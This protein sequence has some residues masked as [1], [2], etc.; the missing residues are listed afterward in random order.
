MLSG[1]VAD[2][3]TT[4][5]A[6]ELV[7]HSSPYFICILLFAASFELGTAMVHFFHGFPL[8]FVGI[9]VFPF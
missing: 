5:V 8:I 1:Q 6:G 2:G 7:C 3:L 4:I 9:F